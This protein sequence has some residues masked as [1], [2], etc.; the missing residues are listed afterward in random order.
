MSG[1]CR[2]IELSKI[3]DSRGN[4]TFIENSKDIPFDI[5]RIFYIYDVPTNESRGAHAHKKLEQFIICLAGGFEVDIND[6]KKTMK[7]TLNK[8]WIGLYIP[9][10]NWASEINFNPGSVCLVLASDY[11]HENDYIRDYD[12]FK[13]HKSIRL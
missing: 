9:P 12:E 2:F 13:K 3:K 10:M 1:Q 6:G 8:P 11:F 5:K 7:F 4:L